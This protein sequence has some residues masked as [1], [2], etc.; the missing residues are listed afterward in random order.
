MESRLIVAWALIALLAGAAGYVAWRIT[1]H[2]PR[3]RRPFKTMR[4]RWL[5][6]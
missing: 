4:E 2:R 5:G 3:V 1:I 6:L